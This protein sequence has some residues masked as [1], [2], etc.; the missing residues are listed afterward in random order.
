MWMV[1]RL[2]LTAAGEVLAVTRGMWS[3]LL[4]CAWHMASA[5][6]LL[7]GLSWVAAAGAVV[8]ATAWSLRWG[9]Q[10]LRSVVALEVRARRVWAPLLLRMVDI[11]IAMVGPA[12]GMPRGGKPV[13]GAKLEEQKDE[14][15]EKPKDEKELEKQQE[16]QKAD[17]AKEQKEV[18]Q[19]GKE[20]VAAAAE[21]KE[22]SAV[23]QAAAAAV[24]APKQAAA[25]AMS[26]IETVQ[27]HL[28][29][30]LMQLRS[31]VERLVPRCAAG[32]G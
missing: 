28:R 5:L 24:Q 2:Q 16:Q 10:Q 29:G 32:R 3:W 25:K 22:K 20:Q 12:L 15:E 9:V 4:R 6:S 17:G 21:G 31:T 27:A 7:V 26:S 8:A 14:K 18:K 13:A 19:E 23:G 11:T 1:A 30:A